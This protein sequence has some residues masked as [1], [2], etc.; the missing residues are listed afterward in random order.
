MGN[1][2]R[3]RENAGARDEKLAASRKPTGPDGQR[4]EHC[5]APKPARYV[6]R[7]IT[8]VASTAE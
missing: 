6:I 5:D 2:R 7:P 4:G 8:T 1:E 3:E